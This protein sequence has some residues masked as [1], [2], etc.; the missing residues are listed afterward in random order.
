[1][2]QT[3]R[4][5]LNLI[6]TFSR[7][8]FTMASGFLAGR[9]SLMVLGDE[10]FGLLVLIGGLMEFIR[11]FSFV[12]STSVSRYY[13][14]AIGEAKKNLILG[15][16]ECRSWFNV[17]LFIHI[18]APT[19]FLILGYPLGEYAIRNE[20]LNIPPNRVEDC[21]WIF[22]FSCISCFV[23]FAHTPFRAMFIA[24][25][26]IADL[27]IYTFVGETLHVLVLWYM[28]THTNDWLLG[29]SFWMMLQLVGPAVIIAIRALCIFPECR[30]SIREMLNFNRM[31]QL[32]SFAGWQFFGNFGA[33][34]QTQ[35]NTIFVNLFLGPKFNATSGVAYTLSGRTQH[36]SNEMNGVFT[37]AITS[38]YGANHKDEARKLAYMCSKY[39]VLI[40]LFCIIP[41]S[42]EIQA[43]IGIWLAEPPEGVYW[44]CILISVAYLIIKLTCGQLIIIE[45]SGRIMQAK[46]CAFFSYV[47]GPIVAAVCFYCNKNIFWL[48]CAMVLSAILLSSFYLLCARKEGCRIRDWFNLVFKPIVLVATISLMTGLLVVFYLKTS[49]WRCLVVGF[50]TSITWLVSTWLFALSSQEK[51][52]VIRKLKRKRKQTVSK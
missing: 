44:L 16:K 37:P 48:G 33:M 10:S 1:M 15:I 50:A 30:I 17:A 36:F 18:V 21:V 8:V 32:F 19:I 2:T 12:F 46:L 45:A 26:L 5:I 42:L 23:G 13:A 35:L 4:I 3:R 7:V 43:M 20:W 11:I 29:I 47:M 27:T 24:K 9:W 22:R 34:L 40:M 38:N 14:Y 6:A 41:L 52:W 31:K 51:E 28:V 49:L 25:Q 39:S